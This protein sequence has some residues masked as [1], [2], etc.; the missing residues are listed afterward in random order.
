MADPPKAYFLERCSG[1]TSPFL[2]LTWPLI[3]ERLRSACQYFCKFVI[4]ETPRHE[5]RR[6]CWKLRKLRRIAQFGEVFREHLANIVVF[7]SGNASP[8]F[9][10]FIPETPR[11]Y[12]GV[13]F[14]KRLAGMRSYFTSF[15]ECLANISRFHSGN[16]YL[17]PF[18]ILF[19]FKMCDFIK[20]LD[21]LLL[22][23]LILRVCWMCCLT[24]TIEN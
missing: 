7:H 12:F 2:S 8:L 23:E 18:L 1:N 15:R 4:P 20:R 11:Q 17:Q 24:N 19:F 6:K 10:C 13:S 16:A 14:R 5:F 22:K 3:W 21:T 9:H